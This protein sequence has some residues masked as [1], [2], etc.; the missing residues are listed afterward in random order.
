MSFLIPGFFLLFESCRGPS[1]GP[2][3]VEYLRWEG[4]TMG[5][6]YMVKVALF[7][8]QGGRLMNFDSM[9][10][11][12]EVKA[13]KEVNS[14]DFQNH[15]LFQNAIDS[16]L[17]LVNA[18]MSTYREHSLISK[19]NASP[20]GMPVDTMMMRNYELSRTVFERSGGAFDPTV[21]PLVQAW[22]FGPHARQSPPDS[23]RIRKILAWVGLDRIQRRGDSLIK[24]RPEQMLDFSAVAKGYGV[25]LVGWFLESQGIVNYLVEIG[26]EV[27]A[28]GFR[29]PVKSR[30]TKQR[31]EPAKEWNVAIEKPLDDPSGSHRAMLLPLPLRN[32]SM[33]SSGNYRNYY[34]LNGRKI[35]HT[36]QPSTG[37]PVPSDLL[38]VTILAPDCMT[39][40]A[41][42]TACMAMG[43]QASKDMIERYQD[44]EAIWIMDGTQAGTYRVEYS[45]GIAALAPALRK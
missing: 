2:N 12:F 40:D 39:A 11:E 45:S 9:G 33:A 44:V 32:Q 37:Y 7:R 17:E 22:G 42:A 26:G 8:N 31:S 25:D 24:S 20:R 18:S 14:I 1:N 35:V 15:R 29:E 16:V 19:W 41:Y 13:N 6:T 23:Q 27:R 43:Y 38:A 36:M 28:R 10:R 30:G 5:T 21:Y 4:S 3:K 34:M